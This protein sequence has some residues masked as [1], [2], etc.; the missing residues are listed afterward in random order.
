M[1]GQFAPS[2]GSGFA[3]FGVQPHDDVAAESAAGIGQKSRV[4]DCGGADDDIAHTRIDVLLDGFQIANTA[5]NLHG[6]FI[7]QLL[8]DFFDDAQVFGL[9]GKRAVEIDQMQA[10]CALLQPVQ[11]LFNRVGIEGGGLVHVAL[12]QAYALAVFQIDSG[13]E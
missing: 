12:L 4:F 2:V 6:N 5:T 10:A 9:A 1:L 3:V 13:D 11:R 7:F 8:Q